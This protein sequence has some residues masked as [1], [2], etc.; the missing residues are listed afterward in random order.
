MPDSLPDLWFGPDGNKLHKRTQL[1]GTKEVQTIRTKFTHGV[2]LF[3]KN[4]RGIITVI[5][6]VAVT[7]MESPKKRS[8]QKQQ[9]NDNKGG[10]GKGK[11]RW[12]KKWFA[13]SVVQD[14][15]EDIQAQNQEQWRNPHLATIE[16]LVGDLSCLETL[17][18]AS[19]VANH[20]Q[21]SFNDPLAISTDPSRTVRTL[22]R[23]VKVLANII[24]AQKGVI[25]RQQRERLRDWQ[26][27]CE[28]LASVSFGREAK[29]NPPVMPRPRTPDLNMIDPS[30]IGS[31]A[32]Y[33]FLPPASIRE[34]ESGGAQPP[35][36][37]P[38]TLRLQRQ[39]KPNTS[40][41]H[42]QGVDAWSTVAQ[43]GSEIRSSPESDAP[44]RPTPLLNAILREPDP[45]PTPRVL[46]DIQTLLGHSP[47]PMDQGEDDP[48]IIEQRMVCLQRHC[49]G[50]CPPPTLELKVENH[51][52]GS[53]SPTDAIKVESADEGEGA[54]E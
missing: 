26:K 40:R 43:A 18:Q 15:A 49:G 53:G 14:V 34:P 37:G 32:S 20:P 41:Q 12:K 28:M 36:A 45:T 5:I 1:R 30:I 10:K 44:E 17:S 48:T 51:S 21:E 2:E 13:R 39:A 23:E 38:L 27:M 25:R 24:A 47:E 52:R 33:S 22:R 50:E 35:T 4:K 6:S 42:E 19:H 46:P 3:I 31:S 7:R 29:A 16:R 54:C 11:G 9:Q 8:Q